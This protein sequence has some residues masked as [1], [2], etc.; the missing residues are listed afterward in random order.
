[1]SLAG[2]WSSGVCSEAV[3]PSLRTQ[4]VFIG[5]GAKSCGTLSRIGGAEAAGFIRSPGRQVEMSQNPGNGSVT[6][7]D[8][9]LRPGYPGFTR[10]HASRLTKDSSGVYAVTH[11]YVCPAIPIPGV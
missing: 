1:M 8:N 2:E 6:I 9:P 5:H 11:N 7:A 3:H 4:T 10:V